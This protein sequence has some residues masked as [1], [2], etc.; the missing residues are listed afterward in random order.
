MENI[1]QIEV[2]RETGF[3]PYGISGGIEREAWKMV[4][5]NTGCANLARRNSNTKAYCVNVIT[6]MRFWS[7]CEA[8]QNAVRNAAL[9]AGAYEQF[10]HS[11]CTLWKK[12]G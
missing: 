3:S 9:A 10:M 7:D 11:S 4:T 8:E 6:V 2:V 12:S 1:E 5:R